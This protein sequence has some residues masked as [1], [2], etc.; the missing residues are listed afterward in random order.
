MALL[1][2]IKTMT[3]RNVCTLRKATRLGNHT[4]SLQEFLEWNAQSPA[5]DCFKHLGNHPMGV[6]DG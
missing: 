1:L 3:M 2:L 6:R 5:D 4:E